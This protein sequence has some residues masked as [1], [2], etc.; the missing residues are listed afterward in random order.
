[1]EFENSNVSLILLVSFLVYDRQAYNYHYDVWAMTHQSIQD[2]CS[3]GLQQSLFN[4]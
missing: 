3:D 1:M 2:T 4:A